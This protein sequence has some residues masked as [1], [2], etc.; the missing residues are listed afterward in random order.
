MRGSP[1]YSLVGR[2]NVLEENNVSR[3]TSLLPSDL[4]S[5]SSRSLL[6]VSRPLLGQAALE[7]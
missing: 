1:P 4:S 5:P 3:K 2:K 7:F 6:G